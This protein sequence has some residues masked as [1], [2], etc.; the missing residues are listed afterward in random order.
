M[1]ST[2]SFVLWA[3]LAV[4]ATAQTSCSGPI[5]LVFALDES[6]SVGNSNYQKAKD[7]MKTVVARFDVGAGANQA[8]VAVMTFSTNAELNWKLNQYN[9]MSAVTNA[10]SSIAYDS[11]WTCTG[12]AMEMM[13]DQMLCPSCGGYRAAAKRVVLFLTDGNPSSSSRCT[14][15]VNRETAIDNLKL[16]ADRVVPVGIGSGIATGY[17]QTLS[18]NMPPSQ[19]YILATYSNLGSILDDLVTVAW[20]TSSPTMPT[21]APTAVPTT[22]PTKVPTTSPSQAPTFSC[23]CDPSPTG[24]NCDATNG[25]CYATDVSC[26]IKKCGCNSGFECNGAAC[27]GASACTVAPTASPTT[28]NPTSAPSTAQPTTA[29][30]TSAPTAPTQSPTYWALFAKGSDSQEEA[31]AQ[32]AGAVAATGLGVVAILAIVL[33]VVAAIV[34][35]VMVAGGIGIF[36]VK[37]HLFET[38]V[39][40]DGK[41][42]Q[43]GHA[44]PVGV[45]LTPEQVAAMG[46]NDPV[47]PSGEVL[48]SYEESSTM[49]ITAFKG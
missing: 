32:T 45:T 20:P 30:P 14:P 47:G 42:L 5:D 7:F 26:A 38:E 16:V 9:S 41:E 1:R 37:Q 17:L 6:G 25:F 12:K 27:T 44:A 28:D 10:I 46:L 24:L 2:S 13:T 23:T 35:V 21:K 43:L 22:A 3:A 39:T 18:S 29:M 36:A 11:G 49:K 48:P 33:G 34:L 8:Q 19:P 31:A 15:T 40:I 4:C